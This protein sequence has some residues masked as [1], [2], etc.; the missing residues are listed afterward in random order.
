MRPKRRRSITHDRTAV[1]A[2]ARVMAI[3][4]AT[5]DRLPSTTHGAVKLGSYTRRIPIMMGATIARTPS[6]RI[7]LPRLRG[8]AT[9][10]DRPDVPSALCRKYRRCHGAA[11]SGLMSGAPRDPSRCYTPAVLKPS[12]TPR[13]QEV[14][15]RASVAHRPSRETTERPDDGNTGDVYPNPRPRSGVCLCGG[16]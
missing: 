2:A 6:R 9:L 5:S 7:T 12:G 1:D 16:D 14:S 3:R 4:A 11:P 8:T 15:D 13:T 10:P